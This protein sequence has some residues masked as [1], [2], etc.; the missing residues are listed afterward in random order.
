MCGRKPSAL[1]V[2]IAAAAF[3]PLTSGTVFS[4]APLE[5]SSVTLLPLGTD[6]PAPGFVPTASPFGQREELT[7][8]I[9][10]TL[11]LEPLSVA[12]ATDFGSPWTDGMCTLPRP[13]ETLSVTTEP[14]S[15]FVF[16]PGVWART[17]PATRLLCTVYGF[18]L[19]P[20]WRSCEIAT[21]T[22]S[23]TTPGTT[24][25]LGFV[26]KYAAA[27]APATRST[28][29]SA[30]NHGHQPFPCSSSGGRSCVTT[31]AGSDPEPFVT[32]RATG[33]GSGCCGSI[34]RPAAA[35]AA[36]AAIEAVRCPA[37]PARI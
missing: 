19:N 35:P 13:L 7:E 32:G 8:S 2:A 27:A 34:G 4:A 15:A 25:C 1:S 31:T 36:I 6:W 20:C 17:V 37:A 21:L 28:T 11:R 9:R 10:A 16:P 3:W 22:G 14:L 23:P 18:A 29:R 12:T 33:G 24:A 30:S 26:R 5:M